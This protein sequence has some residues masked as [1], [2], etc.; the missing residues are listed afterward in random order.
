MRIAIV[1]KS[2]KHT[3]VFG[4][5]M[6]YCK[7]H[8]IELDIYVNTYGFWYG[9]YFNSVLDT[10]YKNYPSSEI[11]CEK[12][13]QYDFIFA[14]TGNEINGFCGISKRRIIFIHHIPRAIKRNSI[15][16]CLTPLVS[17]CTYIFPV[18]NGC[19]DII[20]KKN[21]FSIVGHLGARN[22]K[23]LGVT[24]RTCK[25]DN[26]TIYIFTRSKI[27]P[28]DPRIKVKRFCSTEDMVA[29]LRRSK[30]LLSIPKRNSYYYKDRLSG[31]LPLAYSHNVPI[32]LPIQLNMIYKLTGVVTYKRSLT[33]V[34]RKLL[35]MKPPQYLQLVDKLN[36][37]KHQIIKTNH[38]RLR[39]QMKLVKPKG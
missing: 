25:N 15:N 26:F 30:F 32:C 28:K 3:E 2:K 12:M 13:K 22:L 10:D 34:F 24:L 5:I 20:S 9:P 16:L 18:Y 8:N 35:Q 33:E 37:Q 4:F 21:I 7:R 11:T 36:R 14:T 17:N 19:S 1:Q 23:D 39:K 6:E 31:E 27:S 29:I 38:R